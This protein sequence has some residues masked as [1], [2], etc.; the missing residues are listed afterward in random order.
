[1]HYFDFTEIFANEA[2][3]PLYFNDSAALEN[4]LY[5]NLIMS[6]HMTAGIKIF[7]YFPFTQVAPELSERVRKALKEGALAN[8]TNISTCMM[9][10]EDIFVNDVRSLDKLI[11][12]PDI[13]FLKKKMPGKPIVCVAAGPSLKNNIDYLAEIHEEVFII[14]VSAAL[15]P[16]LKKGIKPDLV[17]SLD[18]HKEVKE[19][20]EDIDVS[21]LR[22]VV[23]MLV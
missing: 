17:T 4:N 12:Y 16:L 11:Q 13:S 6:G 2:F 8:Q 19:Y 20:L 9:F 7:S 21:D 22:I 1:M 23:E 5:I 3:K 10:G 14:A 18:M 15:K